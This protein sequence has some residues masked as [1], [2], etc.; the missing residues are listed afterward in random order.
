MSKTSKAKQLMTIC[1]SVPLA[2]GAVFVAP[3]ASANY[4]VVKVF[5][6]PEV[7]YI[8]VHNTADTSSNENIIETISA[9]SFVW[10]M[11]W[12]S[13]SAVPSPFSGQPAST[14]WYRIQDIRLAWY[15]TLTSIQVATTHATSS[16]KP[17]GRSTSGF[18]GMVDRHIRTND[19]T[20][21]NI[22]QGIE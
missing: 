2:A 4:A 8:N 11:C 16:T 9:G 10:P 14:I 13:G 12:I 3:T 6:T 19:E 1:L 15:H 18:P 17:E 22:F 21:W 5:D 7:Q 20:M